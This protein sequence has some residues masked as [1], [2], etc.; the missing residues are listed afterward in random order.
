MNNYNGLNGV[1]DDNQNKF[2][3]PGTIDWGWINNL[4]PDCK[5]P[6]QISHI[7]NGPDDFDKV[8]SC[9][10]CGFST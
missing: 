8:L 1:W 10:D 7:P 6:L 9:P 3:A 5:S 2:V 4:C